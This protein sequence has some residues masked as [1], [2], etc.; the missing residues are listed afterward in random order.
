MK[1]RITGLAY[2][3]IG[4][5]PE[6]VTQ[7]LSNKVSEILLDKLGSPAEK[8]NVLGQQEACTLL[9]QAHGA[10]SALKSEFNGQTPTADKDF[11]KSTMA[12]LDK[13]LKELEPPKLAI[14][15]E[16]SYGDQRSDFEL[17]RKI[18]HAATFTREGYLDF[19]KDNLSPQSGTTWNA[20]NLIGAIE[21]LSY[22]HPDWINDHKAA[23]LVASL[24]SDKLLSVSKQEGLA[25]TEKSFCVLCKNIN[26]VAAVFERQFIK[27]PEKE[28][29]LFTAAAKLTA[30]ATPGNPPGT[31]DYRFFWPLTE[32]TS[33]YLSPAGGAALCAYFD[34]LHQVAGKVTGAEKLSTIDSAFRSLKSVTCWADTPQN[35]EHLRSIL[36]GLNERLAKNRE[37][38][39]SEALGGILS[40]LR[41]IDGEKLTG[42][43]HRELAKTL[44]LV[45]DRVSKME[46]VP[47]I[48][49]LCK[50]IHGVGP[51][52]GATTKPLKSAVTILMGEFLRRLPQAPER[53]SELGYACGALNE[54]VPH[55]ESFPNLVRL[56]WKDVVQ[57]VNYRNFGCDRTL[58]EDLIAWAVVQQAHVQYSVAIPEDLERRLSSL[59]P[60]ATRMAHESGSRSEDR[61]SDNLARIKGVDVGG[62]MLLYGF[63]S[64]RT[65]TVEGCPG[66]WALEVDGS[67]H[68]APGERE[69]GR[70]KEGVF[71]EFGIQI[72]RVPSNASPAD[73]E[74]MIAGI[75]N[76]A[77]PTN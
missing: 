44:L 53:M 29:A 61:I 12:E 77:V 67:T 41:G 51:S 17:T 52:L 16:V 54:L 55:V 11:R 43:V 20:F 40:G 59:A 31:I 15:E 64:D 37:P 73:L 76:G 8:A 75:R 26:T 71:N 10:L 60:N 45:S 38:F 57:T 74:R 35:Q 24:L 34:E 50:A 36:V 58:R 42:P 48:K 14:K 5:N 23:P 70:R 39:T 21:K 56:L 22:Q 47:S 68:L 28:S 3:L 18:N 6:G 7:A 32:I 33:A 63:E 2:D 4:R 46:E 27:N 65:F 69:K 62:K 30:C 9:R 19:L 72:V 13:V 66:V 1:L 25:I 49:A